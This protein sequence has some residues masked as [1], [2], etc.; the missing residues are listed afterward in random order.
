MVSYAEAPPSFCRFQ[1]A[2]RRTGSCSL[3]FID[4]PGIVS[5]Y[6]ACIDIENGTASLVL[7]WVQGL[8]LERFI[9]QGG[10]LNCPLT[11]AD[12]LKAMLDTCW[13]VSY[14]H[15]REPSIVHGD[16]KGTNII[17]AQDPFSF[18]SFRAKLLDF[19]LSR[20]LT[21]H[22]RPLSGTAMWVAPE[23]VLFP[24]IP[25][26]V[27]A[28]VFSFGRLSF[29]VLT[30]RF[31]FN[32][33][34]KQLILETIRSGSLP[35]LPWPM[36]NSVLSDWRSWIEN[37]CLQAADRRPSMD[38]ISLRISETLDKENNNVL[39]A[40]WGLPVQAIRQVERFGSEFAS[41]GLSASERPLAGQGPSEAQS[42]HALQS[43]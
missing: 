16:L 9:L 4:H 40:V 27:Y 6:G 33:S 14:L 3:P 5:F 43:L 31:P 1:T 36:T 12:R 39:E 21:R 20:V 32:T 24:G 37:C 29:F 34:S 41:T 22:A 42:A 35:P 15:S 10:V 26:Q 11:P 23:V 28:D 7:E 17:M 8:C 18:N 13:A 25:A 30:G 19:G 38:D 2:F